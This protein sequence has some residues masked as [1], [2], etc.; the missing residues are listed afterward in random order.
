MTDE[1]TPNGNLLPSLIRTVVPYLV[2]LVVTW[3]T[4]FGVAVPEETQGALS[5]LLAFAIGTAYY[6]V[7]RIFERR[8]PSVGVLL[9]IAKTPA[10]N[11]AD[12]SDEL[13]LANSRVDYLTRQLR[14]MEAR[15]SKPG[16]LASRL[17]RKKDK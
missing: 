12:Q 10:Y 1:P 2:G 7:V 9:G 11:G 16:S 8:K 6:L 14:A 13:V 3:L 4:S 5:A 15:Q 17:G